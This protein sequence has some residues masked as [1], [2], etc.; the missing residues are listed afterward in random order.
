MKKWFL[1]LL[2]AGLSAQGFGQSDTLRLEDCL[3]W[4]RANFPLL[5]KQ[6]LQNQDMELQLKNIRSAYLPQ[7]FV[8]GQLTYQSD[9]PELGLPGFPDLGIPQ[10]QYRVALNL[11]QIIYDGGTTKARRLLSEAENAAA[12]QQVELDWQQLKAMTVNL[13][14]S[15]ALQNQS[16]KILKSSEQVLD[17][18]LK[19]LDAR[20]KAGAIL[21]SDLLRVKAQQYELQ[22]QLSEVALQKKAAMNSLE[23]LTGQSFKGVAGVEINNRVITTPAFEKLAS[24]KLIALQ[25]EKLSAS[26]E[27]VSKNLVPRLSAMATG[28]VGQPNPYNFFNTDFEG[29]YMLGAR[30]QWNVFDWNNTKRTK[31]SLEL[32]KEMLDT[33]AD[34]LKRNT[35]LRLEG[36][37]AL[38]EQLEMAVAKDAEIAEMREKIRKTVSS[39]LDQGTITSADFLEALRD[40][41]QALLSR[42]LNSLLL[43]KAQVEYLIESGNF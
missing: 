5:Q 30:L 26:Q 9:V 33:E 7:L 41:Q 24:I 8:N 19:Q 35:Q 13:Y 15:I 29:Y 25:K 6:N 14:F 32:K 31:G 10:T 18:K 11:E 22:K 34:Q 28:G 4:A 23:L 38:M 27:V 1:V 16:F 12:Q 36:K 37:I 21:E 20:L 17:E 2:I 43:A 39:Q 3:N 42:E 40:E